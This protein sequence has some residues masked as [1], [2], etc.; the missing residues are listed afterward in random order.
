M[1]YWSLYAAGSPHLND[2]AVV[3]Q[4]VCGGGSTAAAPE[5][6]GLTKP[7]QVWQ[8]PNHFPSEPV[9]VPHPNATAGLA[10]EDDGVLLTAVYDGDRG[11]NY[12]AIIDAQTMSTV[13]T[14]ECQGDWKHLMGFG[15]H[16]G[17]FNRAAQ[18]RHTSNAHG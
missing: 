5:G 4:D 6:D 11:L 14:L 16:G 17:F 18:T 13:A 1:Y 9:F 2:S 3:K 10:G 8:V 15:I 7:L 12:L